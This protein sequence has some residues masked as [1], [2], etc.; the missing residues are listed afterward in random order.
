MF[1]IWKIQNFEEI[2]T[3]KFW[4]F[5][6]SVVGFLKSFLFFRALPTAYG[7]SQ[8]RDL[9]GAAGAGDAEPKLHLRPTPL[10]WT[11]PEP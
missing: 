3:V 9:I 6:N 2:K 8:A 11:T 5:C 4:C 1:A 10:L 7:S